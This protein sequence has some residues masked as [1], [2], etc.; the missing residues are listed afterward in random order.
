MGHTCDSLVTRQVA[1]GEHL[2]LLNIFHEQR[3]EPSPN[4]LEDYLRK[5]TVN[6]FAKIQIFIDM[7]LKSTAP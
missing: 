1:Q 3:S 7:K 2:A 4:V 6:L 5:E